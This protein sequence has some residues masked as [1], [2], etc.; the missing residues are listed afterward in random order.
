M[1]RW[2]AP[3]VFVTVA[4]LVLGGAHYHLW[5]R[6][7]RDAALPRAWARALTG[8]TWGLYALLL[9][10]LVLARTGSLPRPLVFVAFGWLGTMFFLFVGVVAGDLIRVLV[11]AAEKTRL[12][13]PDAG[14]RAALARLLAIGTSLLGLGASAAALAGGLARVPVRRVAV[15]LA[16][17][18]EALTG[19]RIVQLT[20]IHVGHTIRREFVEQLVADVNALEPDV[21]AITGDLVDGSVARLRDAVAPLGRLRARW[22]V[23]FVTG[24]H[25]YYSGAPE[26]CAEL[27][28]LGLRVLRN[29]HVTLGDERG[30]FDLAGIDDAS[31]RGEGHG[32]DLGRALLGRDRARELVLL[33]H[34][35]RA[36]AGAIAAGVGLQLSGHTH[37]GQLWPWSWLVRLAQPVVRGLERFGA[38]QIYVSCGTGYWGPPMRLGAPAEISEIVLSRA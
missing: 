3:L 26:W 27:T 10:S 22:G 2:L 25:E 15:A 30:H 11:A 37:G 18:P 31:A 14:R 38:T 35:P 24:N 34:Q 20:D 17:W 21:I 9:T 19:V 33:A 1:S 16:R 5:A 32:A 6:L 4:V 8:L 23:Y 29:E 13:P 36:L 28:R 7:V 12:L